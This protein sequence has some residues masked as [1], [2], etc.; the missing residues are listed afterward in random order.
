MTVPIGCLSSVK[1]P[2]AMTTS[3]VWRLGDAAAPAKAARFVPVKIVS[4]SYAV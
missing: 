1:G 2:L 3:Q 4:S